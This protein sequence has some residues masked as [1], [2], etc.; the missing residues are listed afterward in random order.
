MIKS[1][2][3][4]TK[5]SESLL[6]PESNLEVL[7]ILY[8]ILEYHTDSIGSPLPS[9]W[10][11]VLRKYVPESLYSGDGYRFI[12]LESFQTVK[13]GIHDSEEEADLHFPPNRKRALDY[14]KNYDRGR[15]QSW[16]VTTRG[17]EEEI[18]KQSAAEHFFVF[19]GKLSDGI[20]LKAV[21]QRALKIAMKYHGNY[22]IQPSS[23]RKK[24]ILADI[25]LDINVAIKN[26]KDY[27]SDFGSSEEILAPMPSQ[28]DLIGYYEGHAL[29]DSMTISKEIND[30]V[31]TQRRLDTSLG[32]ALDMDYKVIRKLLDAGADPDNEL[33]YDGER[34]LKLAIDKDDPYLIKLLLDA[35]ASL[36]FQCGMEPD[37]P[38]M[39]AAKFSEP[40]TLEAL[41]DGGA[42]I[43]EIGA[44][45]WTALMC[46]VA[47]NNREAADYLY[48]RGARTDVKNSE[49]E[50]VFDMGW[51]PRE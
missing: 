22:K 28:V 47:E 3:I 46:A 8:S 12:A 29:R 48:E 45:N 11:T 19:R 15:Y 5:I 31:M 6:N 39:Y 42:D 44:D 35:G 38:L 25:P 24:S 18:G 33:G 4:I 51:E 32:R 9:V 23:M 13:A 37:T 49:G 21:T 14:F 2:D 17:I 26:L 41:I 20:D 34:P 27:H 36:D 30:L 16:A 43:N 50:T 1:S 10:Y 7:S 40:K